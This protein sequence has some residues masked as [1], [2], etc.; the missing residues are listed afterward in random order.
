MDKPITKMK[1]QIEVEIKDIQIKDRWRE[2]MGD[3]ESLALS[4]HVNGL[5][6]PVIVSMGAG[7]SYILVQ[8]ERRI[9]AASSLGWTKIDC[10]LLEE[11]TASRR[12]ELELVIGIQ[13]KQL[14]YLEEARAVRELVNR[15]RADAAK[16]G[17]AHFSSNIKDK[18]VAMELNMAPARLSENLRI[19]KAME[20]HPEL[21][22]EC[23]SRTKCMARIRRKDFYVPSGGYMQS[24]YEEN[25]IVATP[26]ECLEAIPDRIIDICILHPDGLDEELID[27]ASDRL[28]LGGQ[29]II[30]CDARLIHPLEQFLEGRG[31]NTGERPYLWHI[32]EDS[33]YI[34]YIWAATN[35]RQTAR[36]LTPMISIERPSPH[37]SSKAK[38]CKLI[39]AILRS[40]VDRGS[41]VVVPE[42]WA[43]DTVRTAVEMGMNIRAAC[44]DKTLRDRLILSVTKENL[45]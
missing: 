44:A 14:S 7:D 15:R 29:L 40:C 43:I 36:P 26:M 32:K 28:K 13:R 31:F 22:S 11:L 34:N 24:A 5:L 37:Y 39:A 10:I 20:E 30:F 2:D 17:L 3:I 6:Y 16:G 35:R 41:F 33:D 23:M 25:F 18:D 9:H 38:P 45:V 12:K 19:A 8:G 21:I 42:C 4:M 1:T 27:A